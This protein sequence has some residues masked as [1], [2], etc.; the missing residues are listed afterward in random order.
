M[1]SIFRTRG[2]GRDH[3]GPCSAVDGVEDS[4]CHRDRASNREDMTILHGPGLDAAVKIERPDANGAR[5]TNQ[6]FRCA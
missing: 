6:G 2:T 1:D 5:K 4:K 3:G